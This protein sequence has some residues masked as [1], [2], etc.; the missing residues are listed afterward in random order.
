MY[1]DL[2]EK[3]DFGD[4]DLQTLVG[5]ILRYGV[6]ASLCIVFIGLIIY[7][8]HARAEVVHFSTFTKK[9]F[10]FLAFFSGILHGDSLSIIALGVLLLILTPI[11]RVIFAIIG[12]H[13]EKDLR[14]TI[15]SVIVL[16]VIIISTI[17]GAAF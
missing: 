8:S 2:K 1:N 7:L 10:N 13:K 6:L 9:D 17:L 4:K 12:F 3:K 11:M 14:Y 16:L 15:V 5:N